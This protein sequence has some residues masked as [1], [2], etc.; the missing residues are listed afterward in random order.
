MR[1]PNGPSSKHVLKNDELRP[2][3]EAQ[4][5]RFTALEVA[6]RDLACSVVRA[7]A[8]QV[9]CP[10]LRRVVSRCGLLVNMECSLPE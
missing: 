8:I 1:S 10:V 7:G 9:R 6:L 3:L 5:V 2:E 4:G